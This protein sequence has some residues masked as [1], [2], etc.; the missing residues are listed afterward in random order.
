LNEF[1]TT[2]RSP[3]T[4]ISAK[5]Q[6]LAD[7]AAADEAIVFNDIADG[8]GSVMG[9]MSRK[10]IRSCLHVPVTIDGI[11][12]TVNFW[13]AEPKAFPQQAVEYLTAVARLLDDNNRP[14]E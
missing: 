10:G 4:I 7:A 9:R 13:S 6:S 14:K 1:E 3:A 8:K 2:L 12:S 11:R 5:G